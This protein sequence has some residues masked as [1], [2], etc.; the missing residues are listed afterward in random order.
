MPDFFEHGRSMEAS[1]VLW[2]I[3]ILCLMTLAYLVF[4]PEEKQRELKKSCDE[5]SAEVLG[6]KKMEEFVGKQDAVK[7]KD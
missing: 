5:Y 2:A 6:T 4:V 1:A 3:L 7:K